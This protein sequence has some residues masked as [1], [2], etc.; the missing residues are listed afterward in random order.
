MTLV[1]AHT[2]SYPRIGD[3][4]ELQLLRRTIA[5]VDRGDRDAGDLAEAESQMTRRAIDEQLAAGLDVVTD[6]QIRWND[7]VSY[8]AGKLDGVRVN[9]L[10]R[11]FDTN[12]YFRQPVLARRPARTRELVVGDFAVASEA[13]KAAGGNGRRLKPVL[14]GPYTLARLSLAESAE[15][16]ALE[17]R[18]AAYAEALAAEVGALADAGAA[19]VQ[20]DEPSILLFPGD[21]PLFAQAMGQ[22]LRARDEARRRRHT[23]DLILQVYFHDCAPLYE[24]LI[25]LPVDGVGLDFIYNPRLADL[26]AQAGSPVPLGLGVVDGRNTKLERPEDVAR[27]V[28]RMLPRIARARAWLGPSCGLEYLPRDRARAKLEL[29]GKIRAALAGR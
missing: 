10:L 6:G 27:Q 14:T 12:F 28:A 21:W 23:I 22:L 18:V 1:L 2:G 11:L 13:L 3:S 17:P 5:G 7:P 4:P 26:V 15:M 29:L 16:R 25:G 19:E 20:I 8:L 9:G 24:K